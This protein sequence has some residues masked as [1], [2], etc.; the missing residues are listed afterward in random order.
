MAAANVELAPDE[1]ARLAARFTPITAAAPDEVA[2]IQ[3]VVREHL[4][5]GPPAPVA[6]I[7]DFVGHHVRDLL[8]Q[9]LGDPRIKPVIARLNAIA[10][11]QEPPKPGPEIALAGV[12]IGLATVAGLGVAA[13]Y[14]YCVSGPDPA[15][16]ESVEARCN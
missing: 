14:L 2:L 11:E 1:L 10:A 8:P 15:P 3:Q 9:L 13:Y 16:G 5:L 7:W 6:D 12:A 4:T